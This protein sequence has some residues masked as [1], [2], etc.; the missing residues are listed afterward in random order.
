[1]V[2]CLL[3]LVPAMAD[4]CIQ[5]DTIKLSIKRNAAALLQGSSLGKLSDVN[6]FSQPPGNDCC[7]HDPSIFHI[8]FTTKRVIK[9]GEFQLP[10]I[11]FSVHP[12]HPK[13]EEKLNFKSASIAITRAGFQPIPPKPMHMKS[14]E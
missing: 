10:C 9:V 5:L 14:K 13:R 3:Q 6:F 2:I 8:E 11:F 4:H 1:M 7:Q 12:G